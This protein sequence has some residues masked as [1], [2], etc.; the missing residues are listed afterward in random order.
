MHLFP[1]A[2]RAALALG[3]LAASLAANAQ[4]N[5][6]GQG[7]VFLNPLAY[8][9]PPGTVQA[10]THYIDLDRLGSVT[11]FSVSG[12][13]AGGLELGYTRI[14]STAAG[15]RDQN[16]LPIKWRFAAETA[17]LPA[18]AVTLIYRDLV[19][20]KN[21]TDIGLVGTKV[22]TLGATPVVVIVGARLTK[23]LGVGLFGV[24]DRTRLKW[25]ASAAAFVTKRV[26]LGLEVKEQIAGTTWTAVA[27]R[28][29]AGGDWNV[30][31]GVANF[32]PAINNQFAVGV[33]WRQ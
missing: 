31:L 14:T 33:T 28:Y 16:V 22:L 9:T 13:L 25:E 11:T 6:E 7:G 5:W 26:A 4:L 17:D 8:P 20:G 3:L 32:G 1:A 27:L 10:S 24:G 19:G 2:R 21:A 15:V 29:D 30:D 18:A 12:G 23:G